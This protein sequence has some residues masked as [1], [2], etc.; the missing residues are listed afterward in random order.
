[1]SVLLLGIISHFH[2]CVGDWCVGVPG[3]G[4]VCVQLAVGRT[5][6][7]EEREEEGGMRTSDGGAGW[8]RL[9]YVHIKSDGSDFLTIHIDASVSFSDTNHLDTN[10]F[11]QSCCHFSGDGCS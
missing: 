3:S 4:V 11:V 7:L 5:H 10:R 1:M 6:H 2:L 8:K 9:D